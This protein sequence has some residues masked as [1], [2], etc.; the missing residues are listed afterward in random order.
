MAV[1]DDKYDAYQNPVVSLGD[2]LREGVSVAALAT[3]IEK[4]GIYC[5]DRFGRF[6]LE[7]GTKESENALQLLEDYLRWSSDQYDPDHE[8]DRSPLVLSELAGDSRYD[9]F[10]WL[11]E[12]QPNLDKVMK[13]VILQPK[14]S[15]KERKAS[16][17]FVRAL[18]HTIAEISKQAALK[19]L[20]FDP[21]KV[22]APKKDFHH[23]FINLNDVPYSFSSF[24]TFV[25]GLCKFKSGNGDRE[26]YKTLFPDYFK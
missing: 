16:D 26:F 24:D 17:D 21:Q 10:G 23:I 11:E 9:R 22:P 19:G 18:I 15:F 12:N 1:T 14:T 25:H 3:A 5:Y 13:G 4:G 20:E 2:L 8:D 6:N 7:K